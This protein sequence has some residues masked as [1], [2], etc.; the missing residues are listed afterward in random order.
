MEAWF[1]ANLFGIARDI[2]FPENSRNKVYKICG[3]Y[4]YLLISSS[5]FTL[6]LIGK[7]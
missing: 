6:K 4:I 1:L 5:R 3:S 2:F 7:K